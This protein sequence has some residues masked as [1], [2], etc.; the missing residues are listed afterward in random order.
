[1]P[2]R[3]ER[4]SSAEMR[5]VTNLRMKRLRRDG[6]SGS[7]FSVVAAWEVTPRVYLALADAASFLLLSD[8][9]F[10]SPSPSSHRRLAT[11]LQTC[12]HL[13]PTGSP[14]SMREIA[15]IRSGNSSCG[16]DHILRRC[17][18][19]LPKAHQYKAP[20]DRPFA[21]QGARSRSVPG[22]TFR[23]ASPS[24]RSETLRYA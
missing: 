20:G 16:D 7:A 21:F 10:R 8:R 11:L 5:N 23:L 22:R 17:D 2:A 9:P 24:P 18:R 12:A 3:T 13:Q 6:V 19:A 4:H 14:Q 1:M 15:N